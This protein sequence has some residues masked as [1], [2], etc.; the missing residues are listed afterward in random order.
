MHVGSLESTKKMRK[1]CSRR[2]NKRF[3]WLVTNTPQ[4]SSLKENFF[5]RTENENLL[6]YSLTINGN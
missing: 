2:R 5:C 1:S 6:I 4:S 3:Y